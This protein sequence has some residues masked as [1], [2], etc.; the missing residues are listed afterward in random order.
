MALFYIVASLSNAWVLGD[1][2]ASLPACTFSLPPHVMAEVQEDVVGRRKS[3]LTAFGSL[4]TFSLL[5]HQNLTDG[6]LL[7]GICVWHLKPLS[8]SRLC[9]LFHY[10]PET[11]LPFEVLLCPWVIVTLCIHHLE[12]TG[13]WVPGTFVNH[14][15]VSVYLSINLVVSIAPISSSSW[16]S[17][18]AHTGR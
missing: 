17:C 6:Q 13:P 5:L 8:V 7:E 14:E 16:G 3:I 11:T 4:W 2:Q 9:V 15:H 10:N 1:G 12:N 18:Q